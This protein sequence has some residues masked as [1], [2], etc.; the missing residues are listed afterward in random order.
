MAERVN[1]SIRGGL[2]VRLMRESLGRCRRP[3]WVRGCEIYFWSSLGFAGGG[4]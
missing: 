4:G 1:P 3:G 2:R